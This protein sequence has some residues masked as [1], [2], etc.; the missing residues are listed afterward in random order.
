MEEEEGPSPGRSLY[1]FLDSS[2]RHKNEF[3]VFEAARAIFSLPDATS[4]EVIPALA[5]KWKIP[6]CPN[7]QRVIQ[8]SSPALLVVA[9]ACAQ[10]RGHPHVE[11]RSE[12][13]RLHCG[14]MQRRHGEPDHRRQPHNLDPCHHH[15]AQDRHRGVRRP[16]DEAD[17]GLHVGDLGRVQGRRRRSHPLP[18]S[19][20]P[21]QA[22]FH[23]IFF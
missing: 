16:F 9:Q 5:G 17:R 1:D 6:K 23:V 8:S 2:L 22:G 7:L 19:Q 15:A 4:K 12:H 14:R 3:V 11:P 21:Q 10:I 13:T 20:V 18:L